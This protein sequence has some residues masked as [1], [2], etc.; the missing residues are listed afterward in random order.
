[1]PL[2]VA[3]RARDRAPA[4]VA[5]HPHL[6]LVAQLHRVAPGAHPAGA[7]LPPDRGESRQQLAGGHLR[8][9]RHLQLQPSPLRRRRLRQPF[10]LRRQ[11]SEE[12][13]RRE[14]VADSELCCDHQ[15]A[16]MR[17]EMV[18]TPAPI[19]LT[20]GMLVAAAMEPSAVTPDRTF[21]P[22]L[23]FGSLMVLYA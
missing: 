11:R 2:V 1:D 13:R 16:L 17:P 21:F 23:A 8:C 19:W 14:R 12:R 3:Q 7:V 6:D 18:E 22:V 4:R 20:I 10:A 15:K 9:N 5:Q